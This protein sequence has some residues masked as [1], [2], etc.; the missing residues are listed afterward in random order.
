VHLDGQ[1]LQRKAIAKII[2]MN[3]L[4]GLR[5]TLNLGLSI[6]VPIFGMTRDTKPSQKD[7]SLRAENALLLD[8]TQKP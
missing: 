5:V 1:H 4:E 6:H 3:E 7:S 8:A 2:I